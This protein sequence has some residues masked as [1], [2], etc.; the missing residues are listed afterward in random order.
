[1][2]HILGNPIISKPNS[3]VSM[4]QGVI[5]RPSCWDSLPRARGWSHTPYIF[6]AMKSVKNPVSI[7]P[8]GTHLLQKVGM[9]SIP[10]EPGK[11]FIV[12]EEIVEAHREINS[13][14]VILRGQDDRPWTCVFSFPHVPGL[15]C[16]AAVIYFQST[17]WN[18]TDSQAGL[19]LS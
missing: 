5:L 16:F 8:S 2:L 7:S 19:L 12:P 6:P 3:Q 11:G 4:V 13:E 10:K 15:I 1:M 14:G 18:L 9:L 17:L